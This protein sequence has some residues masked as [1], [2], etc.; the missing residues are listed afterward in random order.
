MR[1]EDEHVYPLL[2]EFDSGT[3]DEANIQQG[4]ARKGLATIQQM[5][6]QPG[7]GA[8]VESSPAG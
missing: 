8:A 7:F 1:F 6:D 4:L 5:I 2:Q 3:A